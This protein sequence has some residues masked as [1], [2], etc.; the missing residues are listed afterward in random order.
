MLKVTWPGRG[1][2]HVEVW[3]ILDLSGLT[4]N[5]RM[6]KNYVKARYVYLDGNL[7]TLK[8][9]VEIG[10]EFQLQIVFPSGVTKYN[11][12]MVV[13]QS[14]RAGSLNARAGAPGNKI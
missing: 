6:S 10:R 14:L 9:R 4:Q 5:P 3:R 11:D 8:T 7:V 12:I 13:E 1:V 2:T